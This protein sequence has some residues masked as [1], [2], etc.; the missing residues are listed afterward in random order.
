MVIDESINSECA[1]C[2]APFVC[3]AVAG[4]HSCWCMGKPVRLLEV[5]AEASCYCP[6]CLEKRIREQSSP[7]T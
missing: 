4:S 6:A 5:D 2:G 3:G 7:A 1:D